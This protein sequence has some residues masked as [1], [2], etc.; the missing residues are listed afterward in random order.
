MDS[1]RR[2]YYFQELDRSNAFC[3]DWKCMDPVLK[4]DIALS[5]L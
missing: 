2:F 1:R 5:S 3:P 4:L